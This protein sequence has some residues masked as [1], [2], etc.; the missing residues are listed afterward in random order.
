MLIDDLIKV[1]QGDIMAA[2]RIIE[3]YKGFIYYEMKEYQITNKKDCY[4]AVI[5][6]ILKSF[7]KF[8]I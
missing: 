7:Y 5:E 6:R 8:D 3:H 2:N 1:K 4:D